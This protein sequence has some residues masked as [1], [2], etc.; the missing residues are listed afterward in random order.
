MWPAAGRH[1]PMEGMY[2]TMTQQRTNKIEQTEL[3]AILINPGTVFQD[4]ARPGAMILDCTREAV[5]WHRGDSLARLSGQPV[6]FR[7][8]LSHGSLYAFW[9]SP[10]VSGTSHGYVAGGGP[11]FT[12]SRDTEGPRG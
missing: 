2:D 7:F 4:E 6:R 5:R 1:S 12:S 3:P 9:V 8:H 11:G 10:D